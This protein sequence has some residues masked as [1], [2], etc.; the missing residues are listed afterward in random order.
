MREGGTDDGLAYIAHKIQV[1]FSRSCR[2]EPLKKR[3]KCQLAEAG[4]K[5]ESSKYQFLISKTASAGLAA[6][7]AFQLMLSRNKSGLEHST[8]STPQLP[9]CN[10]APAVA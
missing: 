3:K 9:C 10:G 2:L 6:L 5:I 8:T 7:R 4:K 1:P